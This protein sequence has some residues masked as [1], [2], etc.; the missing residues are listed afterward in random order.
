M[1]ANTRD[2]GLR[3]RNHGTTGLYGIQAQLAVSPAGNLAV[4]SWSDGSCLY[5]NDSHTKTWQMPV[6]RGDG[7][8]GWN[9]IGYVT[10]AEAY[11][12]YSPV[13]SLEGQG[14]LW[15]ST[16]PAAAGRFALTQ[17]RSP[18]L[19]QPSGDSVRR[20]VAPG[21]AGHSPSEPVAAGVLARRNPTGCAKDVDA[22]C[23]RQ[24]QPEL[25]QRDV[26]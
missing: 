22:V 17:R 21:G 18:G 14:R 8:L 13:S 6:G 26:G 5:I 12:V 3:Y 20:V 24:H 23:R 25:E 11:V 1:L 2:T 7:G 9:D 15:V 16:T 4:A 10:D 19:D